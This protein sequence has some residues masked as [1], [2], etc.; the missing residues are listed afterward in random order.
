MPLFPLPALVALVGWLFVFATSSRPVI[1]YGL[2]SLILGVAVFF[3][4]DRM[5]VGGGAARPEA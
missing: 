5:N 3:F 1:A 4:W 2:G